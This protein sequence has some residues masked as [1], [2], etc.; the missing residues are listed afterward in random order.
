M[1]D[2]SR[3][4]D[5]CPWDPGEVCKAA[6]GAC[7]PPRKR[8]LAG[9]KQNG[10]LFST[11][12]YFKG[13][14][15]ASCAP[16]ELKLE[17]DL[18]ETKHDCT[19]DV[20]YPESPTCKR[21]ECNSLEERA[22]VSVKS[23]RAIKRRKS[24]SV[25]GDCRISV[26][27]LQP[28]LFK[29]C[30]GGRIHEKAKR[31]TVFAD[32]LPSTKSAKASYDEMLDAARTTAAKAAKAAF[33]AKSKAM[34]KAAVAAKAAAIAR[35]ALE[36][37]A[38]ASENGVLEC[39]PSRIGCFSCEQ[40][41]SGKVLEGECGPNLLPDPYHLL[42][43]VPSEKKFGYEQILNSS[44]SLIETK[45][46]G[47]LQAVQRSTVPFHP[48]VIDAVLDRVKEDKLV[49]SGQN[50]FIALSNAN[51]DDNLVDKH[52]VAQKTHKICT[53]SCPMPP[54][55]DDEELARQLHRAMNSSPR[56]SRGRACLEY[57]RKSETSPFF[58]DGC[59]PIRYPQ[60]GGCSSSMEKSHLHKVKRRIS[61]SST[62]KA[63]I[64]IKSMT[65]INETLNMHQTAQYRE[66]G[67]TG[68]C[69]AEYKNAF[70]HKDDDSMP[71][72]S[73][74]ALVSLI[75]CSEE[76]STSTA[77]WNAGGSQII[78]S[79][80][81]GITGHDQVVE[82][83]DDLKAS[84]RLLRKSSSGKRKHATGSILASTQRELVSTCADSQ[85]DIQSNAVSEQRGS[86]L[87]SSYYDDYEGS[88]E[89]DD[90]IIKPNPRCTAGVNVNEMPASKT[91]QVN[92]FCS[93]PGRARQRFS[94]PSV[95]CNRPRRGQR[96]LGVLAN[97]LSERAQDFG[98]SFPSYL[99]S[100]TAS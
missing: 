73:K 41:K 92:L 4:P 80:T 98:K 33:E 27:N 93:K 82:C 19:A 47:K 96:I 43:N 26:K 60:I 13:A 12:P 35:A 51:I 42:S 8:L 70:S 94:D 61:R 32:C 54:P 5:V 86:Y 30:S 83:D 38:L 14:S 91:R 52:E 89:N 74:C 46:D 81:K 25:L 95:C 53:F 87:E 40:N 20:F 6:N 90:A 99:P 24:L 1:A 16:E 67:S 31:N 2:N 97:G 58:I 69:F 59:N 72:D 45:D 28:E 88:D 10:W 48:V 39:Q 3:S 29:A 68:S 55:S 77:N 17:V 57:F 21:G 76:R 36:A 85:S 65:A 9:L 84:Q 71:D 18:T 64:K 63:D 15:E 56:I 22:S 50:S 49:Q 100:S 66:L 78:R 79:K 11:P 37:V 44:S 62:G 7:L 75:N 23:K 34:E